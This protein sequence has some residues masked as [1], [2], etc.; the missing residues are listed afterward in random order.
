[1]CDKR[2]LRYVIKR[3][4]KKE[5]YTRTATSMS[6]RPAQLLGEFDTYQR[7][8]DLDVRKE[9]SGVRIETYKRAL[10][11]LTNRPAQLPRELDQ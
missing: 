8:R 1:M 9:T 3:Q 6:D 5:A 10:R 11:S 4:R 7:P 2:D